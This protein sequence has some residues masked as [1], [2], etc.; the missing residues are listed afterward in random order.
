M[1][2]IVLN[3]ILSNA[4]KFKLHVMPEFMK[5]VLASMPVTKSPI[6]TWISLLLAGGLKNHSK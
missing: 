6:F 2:V 3:E 4:A 1:D 5:T